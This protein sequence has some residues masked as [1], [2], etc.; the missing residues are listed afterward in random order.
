MPQEQQVV[1]PNRLPQ[2]TAEATQVRQL[3]TM[4]VEKEL[5]LAKADLYMEAQKYIS[6]AVTDLND[7]NIQLNPAEKAL[8]DK[9]KRL[10]KEVDGYTI[11]SADKTARMYLDSAADNIKEAKL[12]LKDSHPGTIEVLSQYEQIIKDLK[13]IKT[14]PA[15][16]RQLAA[17]FATMRKDLLAMSIRLFDMQGEAK[18]AA[19]ANSLLDAVT[20]NTQKVN[21]PTAAKLENI[22]RKPDEGF[23]AT[24]TMLD[25]QAML[26]MS[27]EGR[28]D[29][30]IQLIEEMT[31]DTGIENKINKIK[32]VSKN[33]EINILSKQM[34]EEYARTKT[35]NP[36]TVTKW[37]LA[38]G[39]TSEEAASTI[40]KLA[41]NAVRKASLSEIVSKILNKRT[42]MIVG[43][44]ATVV[45]VG[46]GV[47]RHFKHS[48]QIQQK[49]ADNKEERQK[50][51]QSR[52]SKL[53]VPEENITKTKE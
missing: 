17:N 1:A 44:G 6:D 51:R 5:N 50:L 47:Y 24:M 53:N 32:F 2:P 13:K 21:S 42:A 23:K 31:A 25:K 9:I 11:G 41:Q 45:A 16:D 22:L 35:F 39:G 15:A 3:A 36:D 49:M 8:S 48:A 52:L 27:P 33:P 4:V 30:I 19:T 43:A 18:V 12:L 34:M 7:A 10:G 40:Q 46:Y 37:V 20:A 38:N 29:C 28:L 26:N 14:L